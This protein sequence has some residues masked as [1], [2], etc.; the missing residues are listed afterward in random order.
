MST[1]ITRVVRS[2][3]SARAAYNRMGKWYDLLAGN[4][5]R[6]FTEA[7]LQKLNI[8]QGET[9]LEIGFGTGHSIV[10]LAQQVGESG[11]VCGIDLSDGMLHVATE[12]LS[13]HGLSSRVELHCGDAAHLPFPGQFFDAVFMSFVI[14]LF[15]TPDLPLV[16]QECRRVLKPTGRV[17]IVSLAKKETTAV[18][19]YEWFHLRFPAAVDCRPIY[20]RRTVEETGF[21]ITDAAEMTM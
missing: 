11:R 2:K 9:V 15:D 17:G 3:D 10:T 4:S 21:L 19:I 18:K 5:E 8:T 16:L 14:E 1:E 6:K 12:R 7:G 13:K 20:A